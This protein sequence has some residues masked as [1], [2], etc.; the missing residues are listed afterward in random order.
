MYPPPSFKTSWS[1]LWITDIW[2]QILLIRS[3]NN[4]SYCLFCFRFWVL[5]IAQW[6]PSFV[7]FFFFFFS[8]LNQSAQPL[9]SKA[10]ER[11]L[12]MVLRVLPDKCSILPGTVY[13]LPVSQNPLPKVFT[14]Q[15]CH[16]SARARTSADLMVERLSGNIS[17]LVCWGVDLLKS[18]TLLL[19]GADNTQRHIQ[20]LTIHFEKR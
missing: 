3:G 20:S 16:F 5:H 17:T 15:M 1:G 19:P 12:P 10:S 9:T 7:D 13:S 14:N 18:P 8:T 6:K 4:V 2:S 11:N